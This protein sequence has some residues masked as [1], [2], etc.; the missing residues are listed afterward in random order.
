MSN[1][2][3][4]DVAIYND[5]KSQLMAD[6]DLLGDDEALLT[7]LDVATDLKDRLI[8]ILRFAKE[9]EAYVD[10]LS[11]LIADMDARQK[12]LKARSARL[13]AVVSWAMQEIGERRID[14]PDLTATLSEGKRELIVTDEA[15]AIMRHPRIKPAEL[16]RVDLRKRLETNETI[17]YAHLGN[18]RPVLTIRSK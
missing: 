18:T 3:A 14:A 2:L 1:T 5:L 9:Q 10:A 11:Y 7:S 12:R 13:R 15:L 4:R 16:D 17:E 6:F 8:R